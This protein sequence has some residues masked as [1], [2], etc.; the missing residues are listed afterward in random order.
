MQANDVLGEMA[1]ASESKK[2]ALRDAVDNFRLKNRFYFDLLPENANENISRYISVN[3]N[4]K[5]WPSFIDEQDVATLYNVDG[6][7]KRFICG[8]FDAI[9]VSHTSNLR[10]KEDGAIII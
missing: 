6:E 5:Q 4:S 2:A 1:M 10:E 9:N 7:Y 8:R 3:P